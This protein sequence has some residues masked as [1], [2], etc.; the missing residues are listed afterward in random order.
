MYS[1]QEPANTDRSA[2]QS[3]GLPDEVRERIRYHSFATHP[4]QSGTAIQSF[5]SPGGPR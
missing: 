1:F 2:L 5:A 3:P 4:L